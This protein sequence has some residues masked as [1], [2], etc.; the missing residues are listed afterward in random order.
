MSDTIQIILVFLVMIVAIIYAKKFQ[1]VRMIKAR[2]VI[3]RDLREK[4]ALS[5]DNAI[6]LPYARS[7]MLKVGFRDERPRILRQMLQHG[8]VGMTEEK[9]FFLNESALIPEEEHSPSEA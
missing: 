7:S 2:D 3:L 5:E 6:D 1:T 9:R 4:G 8:I